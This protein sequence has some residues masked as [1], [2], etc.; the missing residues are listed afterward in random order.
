MENN[1]FSLIPI[2]KT[3]EEKKRKKKNLCKEVQ[4]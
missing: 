1:G 3:L 4:A 2:K